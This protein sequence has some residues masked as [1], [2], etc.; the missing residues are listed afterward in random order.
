M[1]ASCVRNDEKKKWRVFLFA[2]ALMAV[3]FPKLEEL[4]YHNNPIRKFTSPEGDILWIPK[5][6]GVIIGRPE[7]D[8]E[9]HEG[10]CGYDV[11]DGTVTL[12]VAQGDGK[13][14]KGWILF[15]GME[16][17]IQTSIRSETITFTLDGKVAVWP[18]FK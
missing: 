8:S 7:T 3:T 11:S 17:L 12:S 2:A 18:V 13:R 15:P 1:S 16:D 9:Y 10:N 5:S 14:F 6:E 4:R